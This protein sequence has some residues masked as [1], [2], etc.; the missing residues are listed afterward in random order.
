MQYILTFT[1][2]PSTVLSAG[3]LVLRL[4]GEHSQLPFEESLLPIDLE[5]HFISVVRVTH[6]Q[7]NASINEL[8][9][10]DC[11]HVISTKIENKTASPA[12]RKSPCTIFVAN[13]IFYFEFSIVLKFCFCF[14][15]LVFFLILLPNII[16]YY[17]AK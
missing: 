10:I 4:E 9:Q 3:D 11:T 7:K 14:Q 15:N 6:I 16:I 2:W 17:P 12:P 8:S 13:F 1:L 5:H